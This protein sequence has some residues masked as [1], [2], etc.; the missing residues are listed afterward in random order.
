MLQ[1]LMRPSPL[2]PWSLQL[3]VLT[4]PSVTPTPVTITST[5]T[6]ET[7]GGPHPITVI[8]SSSHHCHTVIIMS[9]DVTSESHLHIVPS[10]MMLHARCE[11]SLRII[12]ACEGYQAWRGDP[13]L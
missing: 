8:L 12:T 9:C 1:M 5:S 13:W 10:G 11:P 3:S 6:L 7:S 2:V 4:H